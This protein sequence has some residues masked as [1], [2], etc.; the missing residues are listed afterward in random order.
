[1]KNLTKK[2]TAIK[3]IL[4]NIKREI[5]IE[6]SKLID[7]KKEPNFY[8]RRIRHLEKKLQI[9]KNVYLPKRTAKTKKIF[10]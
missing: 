7:L 1:M 4:E 10:I 3:K 9:I 5:D 6:K 8:R 2:G